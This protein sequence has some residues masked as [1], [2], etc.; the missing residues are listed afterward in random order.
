MPVTAKL[1]RRFYE[2]LREDVTNEQV[3]WFNAVDATYKA[4]LRD[5]IEVQALRFRAELQQALA[6]T[7]ADVRAELHAGFALLRVEMANLRA[8]LIKWMLLFWVGTVGVTLAGVL[9][10]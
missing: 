8:D 9:A 1:S 3:D 6:E 2:A 5:L 10:R 4:D 7:R